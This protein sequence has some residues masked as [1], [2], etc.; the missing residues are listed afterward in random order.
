[1]PISP[2]R[3]ITKLA[4]LILVTGRAI[5]ESPT[6]DEQDPLAMGHF[7]VLRYISEQT[8]PTMRDVAEALRI[9]PP[10]ATV[11]VDS[12]ITKKYV[13][14]SIDKKDRRRILLRMTSAGQ[15]ILVEQEACFKKRVTTILS[16]LNTDERKQFESILIK[17]TSSVVKK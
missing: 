13:R 3:E 6:G 4:D 16:C 5:K 17:I 9:T 12:L 1:M 2:K 7:K 14:R 10:T 8:L 15:A 11:M